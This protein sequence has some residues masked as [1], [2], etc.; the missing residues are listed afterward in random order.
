MKKLM[1]ATIGGDLIIIPL[2]GSH[3]LTVASAYLYEMD[4]GNKATSDN[5]FNASMHLTNKS[6]VW[7]QAPVE[8]FEYNAR[9]REQ[10]SSG[11]VTNA[12][13][14]LCNE[15][16][17]LIETESLAKNTTAYKSMLVAIAETYMI[18]IDS[19][20]DK[21][22]EFGGIEGM[23]EPYVDHPDKKKNK[24]DMI[25][26]QHR[27]MICDIVWEEYN[28]N[29]TYGILS[30]TNFLATRKTKTIEAIE[31]D[32][33][34]KKSLHLSASF[35]RSGR[36]FSDKRVN[37][38]IPLALEA[39]AEL[40]NSSFIT[41]DAAQKV[42][43]FYC[44]TPTLYEQG[45]LI[46]DG[47]LQD[48]T[49]VN[50]TQLI[51]YYG[52]RLLT[53][54]FDQLIADEVKN[55]CL[56]KTLVKIRTYVVH[57]F[58]TDLMDILMNF[59]PNP[60][61][62]QKTSER[63]RPIKCFTTEIESAVPFTHGYINMYIKYIASYMQEEKRSDFT[64]HDLK[65]KYSNLLPNMT[66]PTRQGAVT[67][68]DLNSFRM[69]DK[70]NI[71]SILTNCVLDDSYDWSDSNPKVHSK[72]DWDYAFETSPA[73]KMPIIETLE[74]KKPTKENLLRTTQKQDYAPAEPKTQETNEEKTNR[75]ETNLINHIQKMH[76]DLATM[77]DMLLTLSD[78][79]PAT[80]LH[81]FKENTSSQI[82]IILARNL[83]K[84]PNLTK[85][86]KHQE[87]NTDEDEDEDENE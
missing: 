9:D 32:F 53:V 62:P 33:K 17:K 67:Q 74:L 6:P 51:V 38:L 20:E 35:C 23:S 41:K 5:V 48:V 56:H 39:T 13:R 29:G 3:R 46:F 69:D 14:N 27:E 25:A 11:V 66:L 61:V 57:H 31:S 78:T 37:R 52:N 77:R 63:C 1:I 75:Y 59:G 8:C 30:L 50:W 15:K 71:K 60:L 22:K 49:S 73:F 86:R 18:K 83:P 54:L 80:E 4:F 45:P 21:Y 26:H 79:C 82:E 12:F 68:C 47:D 19:D 85:K 16:S 55:W 24:K 76:S 2:D 44:G 64:V 42:K 28:R 72:F 84:K 81:A 36:S 58:Y 70:F 87:V 40:A 10:I 65:E 34:K 43:T 7:T